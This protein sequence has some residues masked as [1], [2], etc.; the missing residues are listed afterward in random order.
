MVTENT[1]NSHHYMRIC[2]V[3]NINLDDDHNFNIHIMM[4]IKLA[5]TRK[6][7]SL[8]VWEQQ[9]RRARSLI[10]ALLICVLERIISRFSTKNFNFLGSLCS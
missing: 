7:L 10:S 6:N 4:C 1:Q 2:I 8:G 5:S 9:R 3:A